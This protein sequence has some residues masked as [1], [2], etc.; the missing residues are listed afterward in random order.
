MNT[1]LNNKLA[2]TLACVCCLFISTQGHAMGDD[3]PLLTMVNVHELQI[4]AEEDHNVLEWDAE[5]WIGRDISKY[6]IKTRGEYIDDA[7]DPGIEKGRLEFLYSRAFLPFWDWQVG[8]RHD[9]KPTHGEQASSS[10]LRRDWL[11]IGAMGTMYG[12]WDVD[13]SFYI[14]DESSVQLQ[15]EFEKEYMITQNWV[16]TPELK[17]EFNGSSDERFEEGSGLSK[18]EL[19]LRLGYEPNR[20]IQPYVGIIAKQTFGRTRGFKK[21]EGESSGDLAATVGVHFWF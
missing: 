14:G 8:F 1:Y 10:E 4:V 6:W 7:D 3:D 16:F 9:L 19:A 5:A 2:A 18:A 12:F 13:A 20:K 21:A 17:L 15:L 11:I